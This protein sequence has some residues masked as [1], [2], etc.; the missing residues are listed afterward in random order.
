MFVSFAFQYLHIIPRFCITV[1]ILYHIVYNVVCVFPVGSRGFGIVI[2]L[3]IFACR[4]YVVQLSLFFLSACSTL[5]ALSP[6]SS[7]GSGV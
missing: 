4:A 3:N 5:L 1:C 6:E 7:G 2:I